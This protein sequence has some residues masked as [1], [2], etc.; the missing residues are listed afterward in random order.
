MYNRA[1]LLTKH[2]GVYGKGNFSLNTFE[3]NTLL[4]ILNKR[5]NEKKAKN[6]LKEYYETLEKERMG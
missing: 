5:I 6:L 2:F 3:I 4:D 1:K